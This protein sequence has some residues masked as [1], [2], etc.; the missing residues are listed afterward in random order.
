MMIFELKFE[1]PLPPLSEWLDPQYKSEGDAILKKALG[2][3]S[4]DPAN[5]KSDFPEYNYAIPELMKIK[6]N[7]NEH[8]R[9]LD[10]INLRDMQLF[11][12]I[13]S[14]C[15]PLEDLRGPRG[16]LAQKY[17]AEVVTNAWLKMYESMSFLE[18]VVTRVSKRDNTLRTFHFAEAPGNF[19]LAMNHWL[20]S[21]FPAKTR[22]GTKDYPVRIYEHDAIKYE[23]YGNKSRSNK[24]HGYK[25]VTGG[26]SK[27]KSVKWDW[28]AETYRDVYSRNTYYLSDQ[29]GLIARY[30]RN[31]IFGADGDGDITS[32]ANI[33]SFSQEFPCDIVT[34]DVKYMP[35]SMDYDEEERINL[36]V[37]LGHVLCA[38]TTLNT[39][40]SALLKELT[41]LEAPSLCRLMLMLHC[42]KQV[43]VIKPETSR[44]ANSEIY[45]LGTGFK[46][47]FSSLQLNR[48]LTI[49]SYIRSLGTA[50]GSPAIFRREHIPDVLVKWAVAVG[51]ALAEHQIKGI[52]RNLRLY[53][54]Y[55][56]HKDPV[57]AARSDCAKARAEAAKKW[58]DRI[59]IKPLPPEAR[60]MQ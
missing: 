37:H 31:W 23:L 1:A 4:N 12:R 48:L 20:C 8:K 15:R 53:E 59:N 14:A 33:L 58:L 45:V 51:G 27:G 36:P 52:E 22:G 17:G 41:L 25:P 29:Y 5:W 55:K 13:V 7:L 50:E 46:E 42:F 38:A 21:N 40:G 56:S 28:R 19:I 16:I 39:G 60:M 11:E 2:E 47:G 57:A 9:K 32:P 6:D 10:A 35:P 24:N 54:T 30:P 3:E 18:P 44:A 34:S 43:R 26:F 49:L